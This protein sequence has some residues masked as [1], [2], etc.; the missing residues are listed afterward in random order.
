MRLALPRGHFP[1][2]AFNLL[3]VL[4]HII[5]ITLRDETTVT[6]KWIAGKLHMGNWTYLLNSLSKTPRETSRD[7]PC[8]DVEDCPFMKSLSIVR[9][10]LLTF[11][12]TT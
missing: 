2:V 12:H 1:K 9:T 7:E 4:R 3:V 6:L 11:L 8:V 5:P 10:P